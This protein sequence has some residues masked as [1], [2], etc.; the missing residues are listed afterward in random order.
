ML[1]LVEKRA[2]QELNSIKDDKL[3]KITCVCCHVDVKM[4]RIQLMNRHEEV[5]R[6]IIER[7]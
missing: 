4:G 5:T 2:V 7:L 3:D 6:R 1:Y